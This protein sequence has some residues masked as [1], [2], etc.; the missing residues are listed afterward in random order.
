[1][2]SDKEIL[3]MIKTLSQRITAVEKKQSDFAEMLNERQQ[4][5][6]DYIALMSDIDLDEG[7]DEELIPEEGE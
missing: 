5:D 7:N 2:F 3:K 6:I 1:M 4:S